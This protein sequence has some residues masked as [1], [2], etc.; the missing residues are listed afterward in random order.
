MSNNNGN[1][2]IKLMHWEDHELK[3]Y[4]IETEQLERRETW[5]G[6]WSDYQS[7]TSVAKEDEGPDLRSRWKAIEMSNVF[8]A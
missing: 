8:F 2:V 3:N 6:L 1:K 4:K 5:D 7:T